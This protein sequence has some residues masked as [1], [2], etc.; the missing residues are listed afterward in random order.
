MTNKNR[1]GQTNRQTDNRTVICVI[2]S[3]L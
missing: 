2:G 3:I 1:V